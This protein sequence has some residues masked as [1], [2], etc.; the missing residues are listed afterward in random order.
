MGIFNAFIDGITSIINNFFRV[1]YEPLRG[2]ADT[3]VAWYQGLQ[4][5][6]GRAWASA[7]IFV[8]IALILIIGGIIWAIIRWERRTIEGWIPEMPTW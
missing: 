5:A 8:G 7:P 1:L 6:I 3:F 4:T 2:L